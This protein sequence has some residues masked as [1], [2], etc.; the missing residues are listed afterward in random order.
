MPDGYR[1]ELPRIQITGVY[2][3]VFAD[4]CSKRKIRASRAQYQVIN[5]LLCP[6]LTDTEAKNDF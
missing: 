6:T 2:T 3:S 5:N 4:V 1:S